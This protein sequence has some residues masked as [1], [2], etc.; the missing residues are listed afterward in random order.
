M[1]FSLNKKLQADWQKV[2]KAID[3]IEEELANAGPFVPTNLMCEYLLVGEDRRFHYH[4]GSDPIALVRASWKRICRGTKEGASTVAM[5]FI[6]TITGRY[7]KTI[8]RKLFEIILAIRLTHRINK[9]RLPILYLWVGYYGWRMNN[10]QQACSRLKIDPLSASDFESAKL[11]ARL[12]YPEPGEQNKERSLKIRSRAQHLI[13]LTNNKTKKHCR[14]T[15]DLCI[16]S[17]SE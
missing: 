6:R 16:W 8:Q 10:F 15:S 4:P 3:L 13:V 11:V 17:L 12:K 2:C 9:N 1:I 5:Q 14:H 7:E